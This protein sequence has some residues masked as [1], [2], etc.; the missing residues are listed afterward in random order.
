[1]ERLTSLLD[2]FADRTGA[3]IA[4]LTLLMTLATCV[5][6]VAR[7]AFGTGAVPL[8]EAVIYMHGAVF[9]LGIGYTLKAQ[10]HVRVDIVYQRLSA[11][12]QATIDLLGAL[13][14][15]LPVAGFIFWTSLD[16]VALSYRMGEG[17]PEPGGLPALY[18]LKAL[19]PLGAVLLCLQGLAEISRSLSKLVNRHG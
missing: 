12:T 16:Y 6:V 3:L 14:F 7:Y 1:M 5:V 4:P 15:L 9:M 19:I 2:S 18:L 17:S 13:L 11:R 10:G 8:Q